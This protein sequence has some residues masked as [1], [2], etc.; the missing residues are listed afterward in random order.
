MNQPSLFP[1]LFLDPTPAMLGGEATLWQCSHCGT[2]VCIPGLSEVEKALPIDAT[3]GVRRFEKPELCPSCCSGGFN[4]AFSRKIDVGPFRSREAVF[5]EYLHEH[6]CPP[7][8]LYLIEGT[9]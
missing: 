8:L 7:E 4:A 5:R 3:L 9:P 1:D 2:L 6:G